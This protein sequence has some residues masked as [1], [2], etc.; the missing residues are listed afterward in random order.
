MNACR[1]TQ[2]VVGFGSLVAVLG[3][4]AVHP[5]AQ[6]GESWVDHGRLEVSAS[7]RHLQHED[8][9]PFLWIADTA[10]ALFYK[11]RREEI[12]TYLD[13][14][15]NQG[16]NV[17]QAV[18]YWYPHGEDGP[19]PLNAENAY[20]HRPFH[21]D[22]D[23]PATDRPFTVEGGSPDAP[24]D[25]WDHADFV[26][27]ETRRRGLH[28]ALLP[29]WG[30]AS[31][32]A[33]MEKSR[34]V[35]TEAQAEQFGRF[36][37]QRYRTEPHVIWVLGGDVNPVKQSRDQRR[38]YRAMAQGIGRGVTDRDL[39]WDTEDPAWNAVL[40]TYHPD[41]DPQRNSSTWFHSDPWLD[42]NGI[43]TW[44]SVDQVYAAVTRD[45]GLTD[46][47]KPTLLL[48]GAYEEG[49]YPPPGERITALKARRQA[50]HAFLAGAAGFT[51]GAFPMWDFTRNPKNDTYRHT[52]KEALEFPGAHQV[53]S[54]LRAILT[55]QDWTSL[56][57]DSALIIEGAG[58]GATRKV[59]ARSADGSRFLVY[60]PDN[61]PVT[62]NREASTGD[63][64]VQATWISPLDGARRTQ[65]VADDLR[66]TP[67][68]GWE[69]ALLVLTPEN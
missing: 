57:P 2:T 18:A 10:W 34:V 45:R 20:G 16:S 41:G 61:S 17:I 22:A 14:R 65:S 52:W 40:M 33:E 27:R 69:D 11:L 31:I 60:F 35:F 48:E 58:Q 56:V 42:V 9:T 59:A 51:H 26:V 39:R 62:L 4:A 49:Q 46:P 32:N 68:D 55:E 12:I 38:I 6:A 66:L 21:G 28:L 29:C 1:V 44:K 50:Y 54:V 53:G 64:G 30:R 23:E 24:N 3:W 37:G 43:E 5:D 7:G 13:D 67:P 19:G 36:L 8:G 47:V 63:G 15:A 25:Y